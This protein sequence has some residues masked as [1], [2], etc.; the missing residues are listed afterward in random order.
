M[1]ALCSI[2]CSKEELNPESIFSDTLTTPQNKFDEWI[3]QQITI[4][5]NIQLKYRLED[6]ESNTSYN[7]APAEFDKSVALAKLTKFL[8]LESY[9]ELLG[10]SFIRQY[11]PKIMLFVGSPAYNASGSI[12]LGTA[13][14]GMKITLYNVN[15][16]NPYNLDIEFLNYWYFHTMHHEFAHIL[17]QTKNF[18]TDFNLISL[19]YQSSSWVNITDSEALNMGYITRYASSEP[20]EDFVEII[21]TYI[22]NTKQYWDNRVASASSEGQ[23]KIKAKLDIVRDYLKTSWGIDMDTLRDIIQRRSNLVTGLDLTL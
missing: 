1:A 7:L 22:T 15:S 6:K 5:Y 17:H 11:C 2:A 23:E 9:E 19:D 3:S 16:L 18:S 14:G 21:S 4:P 13:E 12:V 20:N 10:D 8:W